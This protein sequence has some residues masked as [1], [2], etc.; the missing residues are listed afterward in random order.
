MLLPE[1]IDG[2]LGAVA[3]LSVDLKKCSEKGSI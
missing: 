2:R 1:A 3:K